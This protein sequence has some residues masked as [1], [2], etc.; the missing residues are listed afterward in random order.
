MREGRVTGE[1]MRADATQEKLMALMTLGAS[2]RA[3]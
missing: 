1:V 2:A 3:A